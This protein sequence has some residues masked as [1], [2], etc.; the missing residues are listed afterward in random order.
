MSS[1]TS[2]SETL[3]RRDDGGA[4]RGLLV[5]ALVLVLLEGL[6]TARELQWSSEL[7][8]FEAFPRVARELQASSAPRVLFVG[9]SLVDEN[10]DAEAVRERLAELGYGHVSLAEAFVHASDVVEWDL[11]LRTHYFEPGRAPDFLVLPFLDRHLR[12]RNSLGSKELSRL[13][14]N[15]DSRE[16]LGSLLGR[17]VRDFGGRFELFLNRFSSLFSGRFRV[18]QRFLDSTFPRYR[19]NASRLH[20][21]ENRG[22][23]AGK[24]GEATYERFA[25]LL[26]TARRAGTRVLMVASP[27]RSRN[28]ISARVRELTVLQDTRLVD[29]RYQP[30]FGHDDFR[31]E[32]HLLPAPARRFSRAL[33]EQL[34]IRLRGELEAAP[35][36]GP[37]LAGVLPGNHP[38]LGPL[39]A[40]PGWCLDLSPAP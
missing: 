27:T 11:L 17:E 4:C 32:A 22:H 34:V 29:L 35:H 26:E 6:F 31:D 12:D 30:H 33:A 40:E 39:E 15:L 18:N 16:T 37:G 10:V 20:S 2:S 8:R 5:V 28:A 23:P 1:S 9:N 3:S 21:M 38:E 13:A 19:E 7:R 14:R 24:S 36:A 25:S